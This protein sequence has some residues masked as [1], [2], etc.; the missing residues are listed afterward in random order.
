MR[1]YFIPGKIKGLKKRKV[2]YEFFEMKGWFCWFC[3]TEDYGLEFFYQPPC[4]V[5]DESIEPIKLSS[6]ALIKLVIFFV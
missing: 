5:T 4:G 6:K 3:I 2:K 1:Y